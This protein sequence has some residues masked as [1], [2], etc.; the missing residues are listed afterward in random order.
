MKWTN[1]TTK[2]NKTTPHSVDAPLKVKYNNTTQIPFCLHFLHDSP[3]FGP[4]I[5][6]LLFYITKDIWVWNQDLRHHTVYLIRPAS[7]LH[8]KN[9]FRAPLTG[10][11]TVIALWSMDYGQTSGKEHD[12]KLFTDGCLQTQISF[13]KTP[14]H[15]N[16]GVYLPRVLCSSFYSTAWALLLC[17][18]PNW[19]NCGSHPIHSQ[20]WFSHW[21]AEEVLSS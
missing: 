21:L 14:N 6:L 16:A 3:F 15:E 19:E 4:Y 1:Q 20:L 11:E 10:L 5:I 8:T 18:Y 2:P 7:P 9:F 12:Q 17:L 13:K